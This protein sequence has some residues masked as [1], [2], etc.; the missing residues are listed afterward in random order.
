GRKWLFL[1]THHR[2]LRCTDYDT[3]CLGFRSDEWPP[4][5]DKNPDDWTDDGALHWANYLLGG[6][7]LP[8]PPGMKIVIPYALWFQAKAGANCAPT[9]NRLEALAVD[10]RGRQAT[11]VSEAVVRIVWESPTPTP[12]GTPTQT[13]TPTATP[14]ATST[15]PPG[16]GWRLYLPLILRNRQ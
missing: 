12:T 7:P 9:V 1:S 10:D 4:G 8:L 11:D 6:L 13:P 3:H 2:L 16:Q 5:E 14:T 15:L